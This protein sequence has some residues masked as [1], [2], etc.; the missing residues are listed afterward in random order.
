MNERY[1][2]Y[3]GDDIAKL[4]LVRLEELAPCGDIEKEILDNEIT[5]HGTHFYTLADDLRSFDAYHRTQFV[6]GRSCM[7]FNLC[8]S[9]YRGQCFAAESEGA[10]RKEVGRLS[11]L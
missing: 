1:A 10:E 9:S 2:L 5:T 6:L 4:G 8:D 7:K 3:F 11:Y